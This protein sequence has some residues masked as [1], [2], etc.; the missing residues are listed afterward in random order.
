MTCCA[1]LLYF[2]YK[3]I[4]LYFQFN[5]NV[6]VNMEHRRQMDFPAVTVCNHNAVKL[7]EVSNDPEISE[8]LYGSSE[9]EDT[10]MPQGDNAAPAQGDNTAVSP[11]CESTEQPPGRKKRKAGMLFLEV[12]G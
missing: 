8:L 5:V 2:I 7:T 4:D 3:H 12:K 1:F 6:L 9:S 10:V 11:Q